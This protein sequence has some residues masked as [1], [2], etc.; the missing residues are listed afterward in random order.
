M[1]SAKPGPS[2]V[3][4]CPSS[5]KDSHVEA[6]KGAVVEG[7]RHARLEL[8]DPVAEVPGRPHARQGIVLPVAAAAS[9]RDSSAYPLTVAA[10]ATEPE[11]ES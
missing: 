8:V 4:I 7:G 10:L 11:Q 5:T 3:A 2:Q 9:R 6:V 1:G